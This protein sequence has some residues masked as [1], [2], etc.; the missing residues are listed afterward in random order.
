MAST[1]YELFARAIAERKQI[2]CVYDGYPRQL[3]PHILG[4]TRGEEVALTYQFSGQSRSGLPPKGEWR[5][6]R[7]SRVRDARL[8][9]GPWRAG[10]SHTRR[11]PCVEIVDLDVNPSSPYRP[12]RG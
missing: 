10:A 5:C 12:R 9:T 11:Q 6:L 3:C 8:V 2:F 7:L 4:H 1:I